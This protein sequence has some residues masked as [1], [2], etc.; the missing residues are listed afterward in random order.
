MAKQ[1]DH[2]ELLKRASTSCEKETLDSLISK[3]SHSRVWGII[4]FLILIASIIVGTTTYVDY[5]ALKSK[6]PVQVD[7]YDQNN[8][9]INGLVCTDATPYKD[10]LVGVV[11]MSILGIL[12]T[13]IS[14]WSLIEVFNLSDRI[15]RKQYRS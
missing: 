2:T 9:P 15:A 5:E 3:R 14:F 4:S 11:L 13:V 10:A 6:G 12:A 1:L 8:N 7:C